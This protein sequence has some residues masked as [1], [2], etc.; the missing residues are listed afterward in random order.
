MFKLRA[1][2]TLLILMLGSWPG[3]AQSIITTVAGSG[4]ILSGVGGPAI[5]V[6]LAG[7]QGMA[8]DSKG[9]LYIADNQQNV[10]FKISPSG[11][12]TVFAGN[13]SRGFSGDGGPASSASFTEPKAVAVDGAGNVYIADY[14]NE[15]IRKVDQNGIVTTFAGGGAAYE[16]DEIPAISTTI[17]EPAG[18]AFDAAGSLYFAEAGDC[19]IRRITKAGI[20]HHVAGMLSRGCGFS[21]DGGS[22]ANAQLYFPQG[23][24]FDGSGNLYVADQSNN[25]VRKIDVSGDISTVGGNGIGGNSGDGG[26]AILAELTF[27]TGVAVDVGGNL[28]IA[29]SI[30][31]VIRKVTPSGTIS[32]VAG[33]INIWPPTFSGDN[34]PATSASLN[35]PYGLVFDSAGNLYVSDQNNRRIRR[36]SLTGTINTVAGNGS[37]NFAGDGGPATKAGLDFPSDVKVDSQ[38][39]LLIADSMNQRVRKVT[40]AGTITTVAGSGTLGFS[41]DG[42]LATS[43]QLNTPVAVATDSSG[44]VYIS[45]QTNGR[46]R[47]VT[48]SGVI[49]T[50][51]GNGNYGYSGDGGSAT[52]ASLALPGGITID[53]NGNL[54]IADTGS[55]RIRKVTPQGIIM[56]VAGSGNSGF[57]GDGG[58]AV[59]A[60]LSVPYDVAVDLAGNLY[61][62]DNGNRVIRMVTQDGNIKTVAGGGMPAGGSREGVSALADSLDGPEGV[63]AD[64]KGNLY[65]QASWNIFR[66]NAAGVITLMAGGGLYGYQ[67]GFD[68]DGGPAVAARITRDTTP[69]FPNMGM[70]IDSAGNL[71]FADTG[72]DRIRKVTNSNADAQLA[73]SFPNDPNGSYPPTGADEQDFSL[74]GSASQSVT[75]TNAGTGPLAW[76]ATTSTLAGGNWLNVSA[77]SGSAPSTISIIADTTNLAPG[78]YTGTITFSAPNASNSPRYVTGNL[79]V[80]IPFL[81]SGATTGTFVVTEPPGT[82]WTAVS[83]VD[84]V[85]ITSQASGVGIGTVQY[86]VTANTGAAV[87]SGALMIGSTAFGITQGYGPQSQTINFGPLSDRGLGSDPFSVSAT[88]SS[89]LAVSFNSLTP[90]VCT[91]VGFTVTLVAVGTCTIQATQAG[92][93]NFAAAAAVSQ[94]FQ[95]TAPPVTITSVTM[96]NGGSTIAQNAWIVLKG[97]NLV[98]SDTPAAGT[99]WSSAPDFASGHM[100]TQLPGYPVTV[101]VNNKPA[102][103]YF[104]C[105]AVTSPACNSDQ[106]NVLTPL[107]ATVGSV[108][109]V[110]TNGTVS[111]APFE[112]TMGAA[113]PS[114]PLVGATQYVVATHADYSL[115]GP[116][117]LS[118]PGYP[119]TPA[120]PGETITLYGFGFGLPT[121][122]LINGSSSQSGPLPTMPLIQIGGSSATVT[123]A[124]VIS[125]GLYQLNVVVP[126]AAQTGDNVLTCT[127]NGST[128][129]AGDLVTVQR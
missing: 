94:S 42:G 48:S 110:V 49:T 43:A 11:V 91:V 45:D 34:G 81:G 47:R 61:I 104:L 80:P 14:H 27:P 10:V 33:N 1:D 38:G 101:T 69:V 2:L 103:I 57:S 7:P 30:N 17:F 13:G 117:S 105:S 90:S 41:G 111:S 12:A 6:P 120:Q 68:G 24:A 54:Y 85:T 40:P 9:N 79:Q 36:I 5:D 50:Y 108:P 3:L 62:S 84:W 44:N 72:N 97:K 102:F 112:V 82:G 115:V 19:Q 56:T 53:G 37:T 77:N 59:A 127:Y 31:N 22:A 93:S 4:R 86:S 87:R 39:N 88:A 25:R 58:P 66:V 99:T 23:I 121:T 55:N 71:Y 129:P 29:A 83:N 95:V 64:A 15:R 18:L 109:V 63:A 126:S 100:P 96:A 125:P 46:I 26:L 74:Y 123:F 98:P 116:R 113:A 76:T 107:D 60:M 16:T 106:I 52:A 67:E 89:G 35:V 75:V 92:N 8:F 28:Y 128:S 21:G 51:A 65:F 20:V 73:L 70:G 122:A 78:L 118:V 124:G 32:T 114:F 119:F